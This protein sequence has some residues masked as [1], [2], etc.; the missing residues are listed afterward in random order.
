MPKQQKR[1]K[2]KKYSHILNLTSTPATPEQQEDG[3]WDPTPEQFEA[4][5]PLLE[6]DEG[7]DRYL[8]NA[9]VDAI[10]ALAAL[11]IEEHPRDCTVIAGVDER[12]RSHEHPVKRPRVAMIAGHQFMMGPLTQALNNANFIVLFPFYQLVTEGKEE[13]MLDLK[14]VGFVEA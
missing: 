5:L 12:G 1:K 11:W 9:R 7:P 14:H 3:V 8:I 4:L 13:E 2:Y 6:F 10:A